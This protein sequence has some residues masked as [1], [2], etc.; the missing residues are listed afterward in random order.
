MKTDLP[1]VNSTTIESARETLRPLVAGTTNVWLLALAAFLIGFFVTLAHR[2]FSQPEGGDEAIWDYVAQCI[3]RGQVPYRDVVEIKTPLSGYLSAGAMLVGRAAGLN[4]VI[5]VRLLNTVMAGLLSAIT[6]LIGA[7]Y[8]R[9]RLVA[10]IVFLIPLVPTH[11]AEWMVTGTE[12]KLPMVLFGMLSVYFIAR[13]KPFWSGLFSMLACLCWQPGLMFTGVAV[14]MFSRYLTNWRDLAAAKVLMGASIPLVILLLYFFLRGALSDFWLWTIV[15]DLKM[16][17][18]ETARGVRE[19]AGVFS[20][21][22][23]RVFKFDLAIVA[24]SFAGFITLLAGRIRASRERMRVPSTCLF[25]DA[26]VILPS[27]YFLFCW[28]NFQSGP[29]LIPLFPFCGM[30]AA[31]FI[32]KL[33]SARFG[34]RFLGFLPTVSITV[35]AV[36][37]LIRTLSYKVEADLTLPDQQN[38]ISSLSDSLSPSD[39]LFVHG[40]VEILVLLNRPN[41]NRYVDL[42]QGKDE[43]IAQRTPGGFG[44]FINALEEAAPK[45]VAI[46]RAGRLHHRDEL[47]QW[48]N[49]HYDPLELAGYEGVYL[50]RSR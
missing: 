39:K 23:V 18:P 7:E 26:V 37:I 34:R 31:F 20:R 44:E 16:Y 35:L 9:S 2:P 49:E 32:A 24:L 42:R 11:F 6:F 3:S 22:L 15:Y 21:V 8:L 30:F 36:L 19:T 13:R 46:S 14:L 4:D 40:T 28:I 12:P 17:A 50:R 10:C 38:R 43:F 47:R 29:D 1:N 27:V 33:S 45:I 41:V 5:S 48:I 25:E